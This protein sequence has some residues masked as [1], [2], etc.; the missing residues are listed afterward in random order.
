MIMMQT[1]RKSENNLPSQEDAGGHVRP[2]SAEP[3]VDVTNL[4]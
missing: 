1:H 4:T 3:T 2:S